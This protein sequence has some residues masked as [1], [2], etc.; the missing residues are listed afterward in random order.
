MEFIFLIIMSMDWFLFIEEEKKSGD[1][2]HGLFQLKIFNSKL[3]R[4]T[5]YLHI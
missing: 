3:H 2:A 5:I 1:K 4:M